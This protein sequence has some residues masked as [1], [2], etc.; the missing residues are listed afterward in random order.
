MPIRE[1][2]AALL[3]LI[4]VLMVAVAVAWYGTAAIPG[5]DEPGVVVVNLTG[6]AN[7]GVWTLD[8]VSGL[9]Y[10]W[11]T[12]EPATIYVREGDEIVL[13]L[14]SADL[15]HQFYVPAFAVGPVD[16]EPGH[17]ATVR[18]TASRS[19]VFQ[20][21]CTSMCGACH[22]YMRG[23]IVVT[24][25]GEEPVRPPPILCS[26]CLL[27]DD[28]LPPPDEF[29]VLGEYL[30]RRKGCSTCHGPEGRG[31]VPNENSTAGTVPDHASTA[32]KLFL[33]SA[34]DAEAFLQLLEWNAD[35]GALEEEPEILRYPI[36]R[37]RFE[38]AREI[39]RTGRYSAKLDPAGPEPPLQMPA[40]QFL[41]G[42]REIDALLG[43]FISLYPWQDDEALAG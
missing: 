23:W 1:K 40:W 6:V 26:F 32:Q 42:D 16:V 9:N 41:I 14:R 25:R 7:D 18:F 33:A 37:A 22:F 3:V 27:G 21:Y 11:K 38:N 29:L 35:L 8:E 2:V 31:G 12:F 4:P 28:P 15:Y 10:W 17:M 39:I 19:G 5:I 13:N 24:P 20:Y 43:Y 36:L 30:Y 34:E